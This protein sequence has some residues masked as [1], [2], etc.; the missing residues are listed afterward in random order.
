VLPHSG[1]RHARIGPVG[2]GGP[3]AL[4]LLGEL[5]PRGLP[6]LRRSR[7]A[8]RCVPGVQPCVPGPSAK[9]SPP[10]LRTSTTN[11]KAARS[12]AEGTP[13]RER[14]ARRTCAAG[15]GSKRRRSRSA[16]RGAQGDA[17]PAEAGERASS[18]RPASALRSS[19]RA[20]RTRPGRA[21]TPVGAE[22]SVRSCPGVD[23]SLSRSCGHFLRRFTVVGARANTRSRP[24]LARVG[25][26]DSG[27]LI[28]LARRRR[29]KARLRRET[30]AARTY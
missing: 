28:G 11:P 2:P 27:R 1:Q 4:D 13:H 30:M 26:S 22:N 15:S 14:G 21:R 25:V 12:A 7:A 24:N 3:L 18:P 6:M 19:A 8:R 17:H 5:D 9:R 10:C 16:T 23:A 29:R 20:R